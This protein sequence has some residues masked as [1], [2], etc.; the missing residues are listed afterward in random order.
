MI[1]FG[2]DVYFRYSYAG[3]YGTTQDAS[4]YGQQ[5]AAAYGSTQV[6]NYMLYIEGC[7]RCIQY[8]IH[9]IIMALI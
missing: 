6:L 2:S 7:Y 5:G 3:A 9:K 4:A 8:L 1:A